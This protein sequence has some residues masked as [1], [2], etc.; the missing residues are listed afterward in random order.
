[1]SLATVELNKL[2]E[3]ARSLMTKGKGLLAAD[4]SNASCKSRF[5]SI[6]VTFTEETRRDYREMLFTT[7]GIGKFISGII[8]FDETIR[9]TSLDNVPLVEIMRKNG[10]IR[11]PTTT[12]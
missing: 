3:V 12:G 9:Q 1:M 5:D 7:P 8:L 2:S 11:V 10:I 6:G 4:E